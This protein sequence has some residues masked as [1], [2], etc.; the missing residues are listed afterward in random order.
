MSYSCIVLKICRPLFRLAWYHCYV[1][2][3]MTSESFASHW[4]YICNRPH[5]IPCLLLSFSISSVRSIAPSLSG[6]TS[7]LLF[8]VG[9]HLVIKHFICTVQH[10]F[11]PL[12]TFLHFT[13]SYLSSRHPYIFTGSDPVLHFITQVDSPLPG[14]SW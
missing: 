11:L 2:M 8:V 1:S 5:L 13:F 12:R 4:L 9:H 10:T 7:T 3:S 14:C 6:I